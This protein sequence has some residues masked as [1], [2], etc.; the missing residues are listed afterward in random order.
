MQNVPMTSE[1]QNERQCRKPDAL[2]AVM[3]G[4]GQYK[5]TKES[6]SN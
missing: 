5:T 6:V 3:E 1:N 4:N 2:L